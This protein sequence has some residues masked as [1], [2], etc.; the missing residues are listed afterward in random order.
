MSE[1]GDEGYAQIGTD[2][3][4]GFY[5]NSYKK[6]MTTQHYLIARKEKQNNYQ[7]NTRPRAS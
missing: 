1:F 3:Y 6:L 4:L 2:L 7:A 5:T